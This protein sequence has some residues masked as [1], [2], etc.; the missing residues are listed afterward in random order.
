MHVDTPRVLV[1][2]NQDIFKHGILAGFPASFGTAENLSKFLM[3]CR[4]KGK[5]GWPNVC[6][7]IWE[8]YAQRNF[9]MTSDLACLF[10]ESCRHICMPTKDTSAW[11]DRYSA[12]SSEDTKSR[13]RDKVSVN[14]VH[15]ALYMYSQNVTLMQT[16]KFSLR[17]EEFPTDRK[18]KKKSIDVRFIET[19]LSDIIKILSEPD[20]KGLPLDKQPMSVANVSSLGVM[21]TVYTEN[22]IRPLHEVLQQQAHATVCSFSKLTQTYN[23]QQV[24]TWLLDHMHAN[25][26][27][28]KRCLMHGK[29]VYQKPG[30]PLRRSSDISLENGSS[31][32]LTRCRITVN[33]HET[34]KEHRLLAM[35]YVS[36]QISVL[37]PETL[38]NHR[39]HVTHCNDASIYLLSSMKCVSVKQCSRTTLVT[40]P[41]AGTLYLTGCINMRIISIA[42][43]VVLRNCHSCKLYILTPT[44][45]LLLAGCNDI[46]LAP[47]NT[48]YRGLAGHLSHA[49]FSVVKNFWDQPA[50][51][52]CLDGGSL[53]GDSGKVYQK[54]PPEQ[55]HL[56]SIPFNTEGTTTGLVNKLPPEYEEGT[57]RARDRVNKWYDNVQK[58]ELSETQ[59]VQLAATL[60]ARF[61]DWLETT[62][63]HKELEALI[64]LR[65]KS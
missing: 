42:R 7:A 8:S 17:S 10:F 47:Y 1:W 29:T 4:T 41:V 6:Y 44:R 5:N 53:L 2:P 20:S 30:R 15:L 14:T 62:G 16:Q 26:F 24:R 35:Q 43:R 58:C 32:T 36:R 11:D 45:P 39:V 21:F 60:Q 63:H 61:H 64:R 23:T 13:M 3:Y 54:L 56:F 37:S 38:L 48:Y 27:T 25:P 50:S 65:D 22:S 18:A 57:M 40:G 28:S 33:D 31:N 59:T 55:F 12:C 34:P 9:N 52:M 46:T 49:T 19:F 51:P